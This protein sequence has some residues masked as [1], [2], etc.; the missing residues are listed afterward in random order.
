MTDTVEFLDALVRCEIDLWNLVDDAVRRS[1]GTTLGRLHALRI[2]RACGGRARVQDVADDLAITVGAAS[3]LVDRL[4]ADGTARRVPNPDD[5][6]SSLIALT[7]TGA[8]EASAGLDTMRRALDDALPADLIA[9]R[10][11]ALTDDLRA[12]SAHVRTEGVRP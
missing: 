6:R 5:R 9:E 7:E 2:L 8:A 12:V 10:L 11:R 4:E 1:P 3:K